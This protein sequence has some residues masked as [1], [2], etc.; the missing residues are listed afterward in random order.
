MESLW[1]TNLSFWSD[2]VKYLSGC[3]IG[4]NFQIEVI[5]F[6][7]TF[8]SG[9]KSKTCQER[10]KKQRNLEYCKKKNC[11]QENI[12]IYYEWVN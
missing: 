4:R 11:Y 9:L 12:K 2:S 6:K 8:E 1:C 5:F 7:L 3:I 10:E